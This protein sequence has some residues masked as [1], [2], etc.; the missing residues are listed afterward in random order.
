MNSL[1]LS[2]D[3]RQIEERGNVARFVQIDLREC[4]RFT[5]SCSYD[6]RLFAEYKFLVRL[7]NHLIVQEYPGEAPMKKRN[8][9]FFLI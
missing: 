7:Q 8:N 6:Q 3:C 4:D 2:R 5:G 9:C 1:P